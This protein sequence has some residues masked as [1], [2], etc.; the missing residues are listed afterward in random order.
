VTL[1]TQNG[2]VHLSTV[3]VKIRKKRPT[4][5]QL[6]RQFRI[7]LDAGQTIPHQYKKIALKANIDK[8]CPL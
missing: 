8:L 1:A 6:V 7:K 3:K 5:R 4:Q 2:V